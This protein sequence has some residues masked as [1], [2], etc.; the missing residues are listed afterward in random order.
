MKAG[1]LRFWWENP[2][3]DAGGMQNGDGDEDYGMDDT[4]SP[5]TSLAMQSDALW[6]LAGTEV[7]TAIL[8]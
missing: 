5:V 1:Q 2:G 7:R 4:R 3:G 6:A 8:S